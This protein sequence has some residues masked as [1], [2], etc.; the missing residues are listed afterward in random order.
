[1]ESHLGKWS[2][3]K[4]GYEAITTF[5]LK[6]KIKLCIHFRGISFF[7]FLVKFYFEIFAS[8]LYIHRKLW[9]NNYDKKF[10]N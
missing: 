9:Q 1:M 4:N 3:Y 7:F 10:T 8:S 2:G 5:L 6:S